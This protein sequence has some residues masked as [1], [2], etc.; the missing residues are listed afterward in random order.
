MKPGPPR[1]SPFT[2]RV[3][4]A[5]VALAIIGLNLWGVLAGQVESPLLSVVIAVVAAVTALIGMRRLG[6]KA[7][8]ED[9]VVSR[10]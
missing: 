8:S 9:D 7:K 3:A 6:R 2:L 5:I 10:D 4:L 1:S